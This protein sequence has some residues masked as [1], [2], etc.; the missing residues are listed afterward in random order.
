MQPASAARYGED[1]IRRWPSSRPARRHWRSGGPSE[2]RWR[3]A[4]S[5]SRYTVG[6]GNWIATFSRQHALGRRTHHGRIGPRN[7]VSACVGRAS[8]GGRDGGDDRTARKAVANRM[9]AA[10]TASHEHPASS[11]PDGAMIPLPIPLP[12]IQLEGTDDP[13]WL[14]IAMKGNSAENLEFVI[15]KGSELKMLWADQVTLQMRLVRCQ[16]G[17]RT[18]AT[19]SRLSSVVPY[20]CH[21][22]RTFV[23]TSRCSRTG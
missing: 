18:R 4:P 6:G 9:I 17:C 20:L 3:L 1:P 8:P 22:A 21:A 10:A 14:A 19:P 12:V 16:S 7:G 5:G 23:S 13:G 11:G 15:V 2:V